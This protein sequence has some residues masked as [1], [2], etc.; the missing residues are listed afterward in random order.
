MLVRH[1]LHLRKVNAV[2]LPLYFIIIMLSREYGEDSTSY[3]NSLE[4]AIHKPSCKVNKKLSD[5]L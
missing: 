1:I 2:C 5:Y 3:I 4:C